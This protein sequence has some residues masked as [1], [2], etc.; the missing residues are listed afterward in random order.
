MTSPYLS[1]SS[2]ITTRSLASIRLALRNAQRKN[3]GVDDHFRKLPRSLKDA[4]VLIPVANVEGRP[5]VIFEVRGQLRN[6][7]GEVRCVGQFGVSAA[8][9][10]ACMQLSRRSSRYCELNKLVRVSLGWQEP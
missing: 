4:A 3:Q 1:L 5:G 7:A 10:N 8:I 6:H 2:P 9:I